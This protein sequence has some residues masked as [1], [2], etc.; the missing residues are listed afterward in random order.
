MW[1]LSDRCGVV[2]WLVAVGGMEVAMIEMAQRPLLDDAPAF[3][4]SV[5]E[6]ANPAGSGEPTD[7]LPDQADLDETQASLLLARQAL[8][9]AGIS[10]DPLALQDAISWMG[11]D[12]AAAYREARLPARAFGAPCFM[13]HAPRRWRCHP[14][15]AP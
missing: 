8:D 4:R 10:L 9:R 3:G 15:V 13:S 5:V 11:R 6:T 1:K 12:W 7:V 14:G 2:L